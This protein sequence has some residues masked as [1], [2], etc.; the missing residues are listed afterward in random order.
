MPAYVVDTVRNK[1]SPEIEEIIRNIVLYEKPTS[2]TLIEEYF[3]QALNDLRE[4][5]A[6]DWSLDQFR[7]REF[8]RFLSRESSGESEFQFPELNASNVGFYRAI[9]SKLPEESIEILK[10]TVEVSKDRTNLMY[11]SQLAV[12]LVYSNDSVITNDAAELIRRLADK[13]MQH[14]DYRLY[15]ELLKGQLE[16]GIGSKAEAMSFIRRFAGTDME[17]SFL[18]GYGWL[19]HLR[20][21]LIRKLHHFTIKD[22]NVLEWHEQMARGLLPRKLWP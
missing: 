11:A 7:E 13:H 5:E 4:A 20:D 16:A 9:V 14:A 18:F 22:R 3:T 6:Q 1:T 12:S 8:L 17:R 19:K 2:G 10:R 15:R 21:N